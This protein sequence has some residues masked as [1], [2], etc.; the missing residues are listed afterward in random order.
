MSC[1]MDLLRSTACMT[2]RDNLLVTL[3][4]MDMSG[5]GKGCA[6]FVPGPSDNLCLK[7]PAFRCAA[8]P[9]LLF[10]ELTKS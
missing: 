2:K 4:M 10:V 6:H 1:I 8:S 7:S 5:E 3:D 9:V